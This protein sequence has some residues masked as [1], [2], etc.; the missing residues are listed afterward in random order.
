MR[1]LMLVEG[2]NAVGGI[3]EIVDSLAVELNRAGH[4]AAILS[5]PDFH[6]ERS[7]YERHPRPGIECIYQEIWNRKPLGLR[8]WR[9]WRDEVMGA[10]PYRKQHEGVEDRCEKVCHRTPVEFTSPL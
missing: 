4:T 3:A 2:Y 10:G 9:D 8:K 6:A 1:V 7:G 5:T